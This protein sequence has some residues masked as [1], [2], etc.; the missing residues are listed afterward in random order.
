M[1]RSIALAHSGALREALQSAEEGARL[2]E[3]H[4]LAREAAR[5]RLAAMHPLTKMGEVERAI[6]YGNQARDAFRA[7][8]DGTLEGKAELNL[9]NC[10]K[11]RGD[12]DSALA[13]LTRA[14]QALRADALLCAQIENTRGNVLLLMDRFVEAE[15]ALLAAMQSMDK[16]GHSTA[17]A[18]IEG[19][20]ADVY[21]RMG[22]LNLAI[23]HFQQ[24]RERLGRES[25]IRHR[26]RLLIEESDALEHL[27]LIDSAADMY[28]QALGHVETMGLAPERARI[29][30]G[31][32]RC[33][34][35]LGRLEN[36]RR[37]LEE[38]IEVYTRLGDVASGD[39]ARLHL[40]EILLTR[41][42][43]AQAF[44]EASRI[45]DR[46]GIAMLDRAHALALSARAQHKLGRRDHAAHAATQCVEL[47]RQSGVSTILADALDVRAALRD[48]TQER[49]LVIEELE[50]AVHAI[51][52]VRGTFQAER[53]R[54]AFL[55]RR[56]G[57]YER[58]VQAHLSAQDAGAIDKAFAV[59][60][61]AKSRALLDVVK[62]AID[63]AEATSPADSSDIGRRLAQLRAELNALYGQ[64]GP[65]GPAQLRR[66]AP[67]TW[68]DAVRVRETELDRL[69]A[70]AA[71]Q[72]LTTPLVAGTVES[73]EVLALLAPDHA[74]LEYF[75]AGDEVMAF[76]LRD[77]GARVVRRLASAAEL[78]EQ[79]VRVHFQLRRVLRAPDDPR[80]QDP[81][82]V[83][84]CRREL[85]RL[86]Q[87]AAEP[88]WPLLNGVGTLS[89]IP[90]GSLHRAPFGALWTGR[91][92]LTDDI[93]LAIAPSASLLC[94]MRATPSRPAG[95]EALVISNHD[96]SAPRLLEEACSVADELRKG[97]PGRIV[98]LHGPQ[99]TIDAFQAAAP[100][101]RLIHLA[102]HGVFVPHQ[103][104]ASGLQFSDRRLTVRDVTRL[105]LGAELVVLSGC[106]TGRSQVAS[107]DEL[108]G[109]VSAFLAAGARS[110]LVSLWSV[111]DDAGAE[112]MKHF[113]P[114][115]RS[116][117]SLDRSTPCRTSNGIHS[118]GPAAWRAAQQA[119]RERFPH[120][121]YWAP[122]VFVGGFGR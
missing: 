20:L 49:D 104:A 10:C 26:A 2:A 45:L 117:L 59:V 72:R 50:E 113:Y 60:E 95:S 108:L 53:F 16:Q 101:A 103:P 39:R 11:A 34:L 4:G 71:T 118:A 68:M 121:A 33:H 37:C 42:L 111:S 23:R 106:E 69:Q 9:G 83:E 14:A 85:H 66:L 93:E 25:A 43:A 98:E 79:I 86:W 48:P 81:E 22:R 27:G 77:G 58:L 30:V 70:Q 120:P 8:A 91:S 55:G 84:S 65:D 76:V 46:T 99:A 38:A 114:Q 21:A 64:L 110:L 105:A 87:L 41:G 28:D 24:A 107:G 5:C 90:H 18:V 75:T 12:G 15:Q 36:A 63:L 17:A 62:G 112:F 35:R 67:A 6:Q 115:W 52:R 19:N 51:E 57:I 74:V 100:A 31:Q 92:Y 96:R 13:H 78:H 73:R 97:W 32:A 7:L 3:T 56:H 40:A 47:A 80:S 88:V 122:Y 102:A 29:L 89:I 44:E 54:A 82:L 109:L 61:K 94:S 119:V 1:A 116:R